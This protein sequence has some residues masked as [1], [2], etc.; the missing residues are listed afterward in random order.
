MRLQKIFLV[1]LLFFSMGCDK[2]SSHDECKGP[3]KIIACTKEYMP[4]C[5]C[6][7]KTYS[8]DCVA[9]ANGIKLWTTGVCDEN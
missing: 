7:N 1:F 4:V 8:N 5:G 6:D 9:D 3:S 2:V